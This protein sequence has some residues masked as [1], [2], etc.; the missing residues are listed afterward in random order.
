MEFSRPPLF[1]IP[2]NIEAAAAEEDEEGGS[3][4]CIDTLFDQEDI[5]HKQPEPTSSYYH[6][7]RRLGSMHQPQHHH[8][9]VGNHRGTHFPL[10]RR[11]TPT[12]STLFSAATT[13]SHTGEQQQG[14]NRKKNRRG[15]RRQAITSHLSN[16]HSILKRTATRKRHIS[17]TNLRRKVKKYAERSDWDAV[18]KLINGYVFS[19]I[20]PEALTSTVLPPPSSLQQDASSLFSS[21]ATLPIHQEEVILPV[22]PPPPQ[23][24]SSSG[25]SAG[26]QQRRPSYG[27]LNGSRRSFTG[28]ESAAASAAIKAALEE[29]SDSNNMNH[30][31]DVLLCPSS[32]N[33]NAVNNGNF[34]ENILHDVCSC[35]PPLDVVETL[36]T[37]LRQN[38]K[39]CTVS[40]DEQGNTP[41]HL[42]VMSGS[43]SKVVDALVRADPTPASMGNIDNCSPLHL[44]MKF[45]VDVRLGLPAT[46]PKHHHHGKHVQIKEQVLSP[47]EAMEQT[48]QIVRILKDAMLTYPGK[49]DFKD[50]DASG[51]SP[52]DYAIEG[53]LRTRH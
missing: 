29:S 13:A 40:T 5:H 48:Y 16:F 1:S 25:G 10:T 36:L 41:L 34:G 45:L 52:L 4:D 42:A 14:A 24:A 3:F 38:R 47:R 37:A 19:D 23:S 26:P 51:Y 11:N 33:N 44:A 49:I 32:S 22:P 17:E 39:G 9:H 43:S 30:H 21:P 31:D 20:P 27:S 6:F 2:S 28:G 15:T 35:H 8:H 46:A 50:E 12:D 7:L 18:R 53:I